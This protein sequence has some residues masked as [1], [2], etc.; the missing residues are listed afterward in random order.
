M[1][2]AVAPVRFFVAIDG[3]LHVLNAQGS[4]WL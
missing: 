4:T 1:I 2:K 3:I